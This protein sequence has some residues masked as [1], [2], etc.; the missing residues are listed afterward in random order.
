MTTFQL[1]RFV[2]S[3]VV[4]WAACVCGNVQGQVSL[5][6]ERQ[7]GTV[8]TN[9]LGMSIGADGVYVAGYNAYLIFSTIVQKY[10]FNGD[11]A[12]RHIIGTRLTCKESLQ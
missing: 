1:P 11:P 12:T 10:D 2:R 9:A 4:L 6:W 7:F 5:A 8:G 3:A